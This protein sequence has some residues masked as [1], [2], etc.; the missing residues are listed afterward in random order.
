[1]ASEPDDLSIALAEAR[2]AIE[3][4]NYPRAVALLEPLCEDYPPLQPPGDILRLLLATALMG[5]GQS[6]R[7]AACCR[8]LQ[9]CAD[10]QRRAQARDLLQVLEAPALK[11]PRDWSLTLPRL[12]QA[13]PLEG[14]GRSGRSRVRQ[15]PEPPT[16]PPVGPTQSPR[17]FAA[18]V[19]VLLVAFLLGSLL[20][21]C[22]RVETDL[23]VVGPGQV[24]LQH[25]LR[26]L[27]NTP[28]PFQSSFSVALENQDP[29]YRLTQQGNTTILSSPLLTPSTALTSLHSTWAQAS[30]LGGFALPP[31]ALDWEETNW[32]LGVSEHIQMRLDLRTLPSLPGLDLNLRLA[33]FAR[34]ALRVAQPNPVGPTRDPRGWI[35]HLEPGQVNRLEIRSWRWNPIG[36]GGVLISLALL[37]VVLLQR[38]RVRLGLGLPELPS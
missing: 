33:P 20:S 32:L 12:D 25:R 31:P 24:R 27:A 7:A 28:L 35:W 26:P 9:R 19:V 11:R 38:M 16:P 18:V 37:L 23:Q 10:P 6:E 30:A 15:K 8:S 17:G 13:P 2:V 36:L 3:H 22:L 1:M 34:R 4:G 14:V 5:Q 29:P 21:G